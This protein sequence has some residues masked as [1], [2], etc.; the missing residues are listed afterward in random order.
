VARQDAPSRDSDAPT[1]PPSCPPTGDGLRLI[2]PRPQL[3]H[4]RD[5]SKLPPPPQNSQQ[6]GTRRR[7]RHHH[8][9][10]TSTR[11]PWLQHHGGTNP[12]TLTEEDRAASRPPPGTDSVGRL[13]Q[14]AA[15]PPSADKLARQSHH[16]RG[17]PR[18][19]R[20]RRSAAPP[21]TSS[22]VNTR[23][24]AAVIPTGAAVTTA[25]CRPPSRHQ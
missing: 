17:S 12:A 23:R 24:R 14:R 9:A 25:R 3:A 15:D 2:P 7:L 11:S 10:S 18:R 1:A 8:G 5:R 20:P 13:P 19:P 22:A 21:A 6:K 4:G 16:L